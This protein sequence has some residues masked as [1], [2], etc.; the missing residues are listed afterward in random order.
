MFLKFLYAVTITWRIAIHITSMP[1]I[2]LLR[3][4]S[5]SLIQSDSLPNSISCK[6]SLLACHTNMP[7]QIYL[8]KRNKRFMYSYPLC[9]QWQYVDTKFR[10]YLS[11]GSKVAWHRPSNCLF[12]FKEG[13]CGRK[14][15]WGCRLSLPGFCSHCNELS[16]LLKYLRKKPST[17]FSRCT[18]HHAVSPSFCEP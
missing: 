5:Q 12:H 11:S 10:E 1:R 7:S 17:K 4:V 16:G 6:A 13:R 8:L 9:R 15:L 2:I 3:G 18:R 14:R